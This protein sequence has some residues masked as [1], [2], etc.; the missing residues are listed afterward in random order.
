VQKLEKFRDLEEE[1]KRLCLANKL[2]YVP[3]VK[4][5]QEGDK[6]LNR[7]EVMNNRKRPAMKKKMAKKAGVVQ[8]MYGSEA[9][10]KEKKDKKN[11]I[12]YHESMGLQNAFHLICS[13]P[14]P[15]ILNEFKKLGVNPDCSDHKGITPFNLISSKPVTEDQLIKH[16]TVF[17]F[18]I[19]NNVQT[20]KADLKGRTPFLNYVASN[21]PINYNRMLDLG[22]NINQMDVTGL[23]ALKYVLIRREDKVIEGFVKRGADIN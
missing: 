20:D 15:D 16:Q 6:G 1:R 12:E 8:H 10:K 17:D 13:A 21:L 4:K 14:H 2:V 7:E 11:E 9:A 3:L 18:F 22:A 5:I 19:A 23:F